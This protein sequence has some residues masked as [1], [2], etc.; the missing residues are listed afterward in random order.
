MTCRKSAYLRFRRLPIIPRA[1]AFGL[2]P[3]PI[4]RR[5]ALA[6]RNDPM[7]R[8]LLRFG[9]AACT[10]LAAGCISPQDTR[11]PTLGYRDTRTE[12]QS[13]NYLNPLPD[14]SGPGYQA[15]P[16]GFDYPRAEPRRAQERAAITE[17][18][19][20][21]DTVPASNPSVS[22]YPRSVNP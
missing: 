14:R 12:R 4:V 6:Q 22:R 3:E 5:G 16:R 2:P 9:V 17:E 10:L 7:N 20:G 19:T 11:L 18:I 8:A 21:G 13:F 15:L 1:A